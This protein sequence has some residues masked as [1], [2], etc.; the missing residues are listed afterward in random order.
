MSL[1]LSDKEVLL[2]IPSEPAVLGEP[3]TLTCEVRGGAKIENAK[4]FK[5]NSPLQASGSDGSY[6][7]TSVTNKDKGTYKCQASFRYIFITPHGALKSDVPSDSQTLFIRGISPNICL[8]L[9]VFLYIF[10][11]M[12]R[13]FCQD[14]EF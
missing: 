5:D 8:Y 4:F 6:K 9:G 1:F 2:E 10:C 13:G 7:I 12:L 14:I 3:L 11:N